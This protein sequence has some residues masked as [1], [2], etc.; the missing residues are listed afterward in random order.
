MS[1][2]AEQL[3][4]AVEDLPFV[5]AEINYAGDI[6]G[7]AVFDVVD[8]ANM[9]VAFVPNTVRIHD[10]REV[11]EQFNLDTHGFA[12]VRHPSSAA[13]RSELRE[14]NLTL[15]GVHSEINETY[16]AEIAA[17]LQQLTGAREVIAQTSGLL[18][19]TS[20]R[21]KKK[22]WATPATFVHLD[23]TENSA[24]KF[25]K[26]SVEEIGLE[27][28]PY[29]RFMVFQTWRVISGAPQDNTLAIC[30][31]RSASG[32]DAIVMDSVIGPRDK[33]GAF[34]ESR[35]C[36]SNPGHRWYYLSDMA[37][38]DLLIF[39]GFD[40]DIPTSMNAMHTAFEIPSAS[41]QAIPRTSVEARFFAFFD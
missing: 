27:L 1:N 12:Y 10:L 30:D 41:D 40:S 22:S 31:G 37:P 4:E 7:R 8:H 3:S 20:N 24:N 26:W 15:Q 16:Q 19:R 35:L 32:S 23:F 21:A 38:E 13:T 33:P 25:L 36:L 17:Y 18:V 14:Q 28:K 5:E 39:K 34:F 6:A 9:N 29:R 11:R 2:L